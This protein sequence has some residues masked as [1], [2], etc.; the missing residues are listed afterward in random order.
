MGGGGG[1]WGVKGVRGTKGYAPVGQSSV[2]K[3]DSDNDRM[4]LIKNDGVKTTL[5]DLLQVENA[6]PGYQHFPINPQ[7]GYDDYYFST[8]LS[9]KIKTSDNGLPTWVKRTSQARNE[10]WD[11]RVL[12]L[13]ACEF[14]N[15]N[16]STV[17]KTHSQP[18]ANPW[19]DPKGGTVREYQLKKEIICQAPTEPV[20]ITRIRI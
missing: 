7:L 16:W 12:N 9:E 10:S 11:L 20:K 13:G 1:G 2:S 18:V 19:N 15:P 17:E 4:F 8:L 6:G 14:A 5:R 3:S